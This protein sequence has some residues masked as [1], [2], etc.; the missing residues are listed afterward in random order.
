MSEINPRY[1]RGKVIAA[2]CVIKKI[3]PSTT[4]AT[5][6][7]VESQSNPSVFYTVVMFKDGK[8]VCNCQDYKSREETCKHIYAVCLYETT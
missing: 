6:W 4:N 2:S 3:K 7:R 1:A 5:M 8:V